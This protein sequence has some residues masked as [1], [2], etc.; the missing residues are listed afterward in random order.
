MCTLGQVWGLDFQNPLKPNDF[1]FAVQMRWSRFI[2]CFRF[3]VVFVYVLYIMFFDLRQLI[4]CHKYRASLYNNAIISCCRRWQV[5]VCIFDKYK[6]KTPNYYHVIVSM[7]KL[8]N[9]K[10]TSW[11]SQAIH[12]FKLLTQIQ[13][14][15]CLAS[16]RYWM[17][18]INFTSHHSA[19]I[20]IGQQH[21][22]TPGQIHW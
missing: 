2:P 22:S 6:V 9:S 14:G 3:F 12:K 10:T 11:F 16:F 7:L 8:T 20:R 5:D 18:N 1:A 17:L 21:H 15:F 19:F 13:F 4:P